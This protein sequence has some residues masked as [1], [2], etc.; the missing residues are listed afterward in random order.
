[1]NGLG[2]DLNCA[3]VV[4]L[5]VCQPP[6]VLGHPPP[7]SPSS[8]DLV[9]ALPGRALIKDQDRRVCWAHGC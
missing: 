7:H 9:Q 4:G 5:T 3:L 2:H 6:R 1:V 8:E